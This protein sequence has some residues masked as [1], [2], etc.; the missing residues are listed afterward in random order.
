MYIVYREANNPNVKRKTI[1]FA[2]SFIT[3]VICVLSSG[4]LELKKNL[5][6]TT[7]AAAGRIGQKSNESHCNN[8][9]ACLFSCN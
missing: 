9:C 4:S 8:V 5:S 1:V 2:I 7:T 6:F 3:V